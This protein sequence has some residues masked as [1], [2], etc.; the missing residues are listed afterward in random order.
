VPENLKASVNAQ[1]RC[2]LE[3]GIIKPSKSPMSSP[4]VCVIKGQRPADGIITPDKVNICANYQYV[5]K[6]TVPD[7]ISLA[8][9]SEVIQSWSI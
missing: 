9:I 4:V 8:N 2:L 5:N 1:I 7:A 6:Y 3:Q